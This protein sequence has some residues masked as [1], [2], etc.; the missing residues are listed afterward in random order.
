MRGSAVSATKAGRFATFSVS[1]ASKIQ[2]MSKFADIQIDEGIVKR[3]AR[4]DVRA[5]EIIYRAFSSPVYSMCLRFTRVPAH[6]EDLLQETF[7]EVI[8]K[9]SAFRGE[10]PI[11]SWIR[12]IAVT[13]SLMFLRSAWK[14]DIFLLT[15][16]P[17]IEQCFIKSGANWCRERDSNSHFLSE[18]G[19]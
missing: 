17:H 1:D 9:I 2:D 14:A 5:H 18:T 3:A 13:K 6:A 7:V 16:L 8:R 15:R 19:F 11:G 12:R 4:G 10:A